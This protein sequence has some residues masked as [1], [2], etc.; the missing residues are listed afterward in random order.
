MRMANFRCFWVENILLPLEQCVLLL[1]NIQTF[2][3]FILMR[4]PTCGMI[5]WVQNSAMHV[6]LGAA[7]TFLETDVSTNF[8]SE[9]GKG[10]NSSLQSSIQ[11]FI[12]LILTAWHLPL[13]PFYS[14]RFLFILRLIWTAWILPF[15]QALA[16]LRPEESVLRS[17]WMQSAQSVL[18]I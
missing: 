14:R 18:Q 4:M 11:R 3:S 15:F 8:V 13:N 10:K 9:V 16:R 7:M 1:K 2:I 17:C 5:I 6:S 12:C